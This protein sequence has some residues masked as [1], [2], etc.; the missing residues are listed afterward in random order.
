MKDVLLQIHLLLREIVEYMK[1]PIDENLFSV[2]IIKNNLDYRGLSSNNLPYYNLK[3]DYEFEFFWQLFSYDLPTSF[4]HYTSFD[5]IFE[6]IKSGRIQLSSIVG[7]ND[8]YE[9][10][11]VNQKMGVNSG[12]LITTLNA[13]L[14]FIMSFSKRADDLNQWRLYGDDGEGVML[15]FNL[16][17]PVPHSRKCFISKVQ[18]DLGI[19]DILIERRKTF[20]DKYNFGFGFK[21]I[22]DWKF[23]FKNKDYANEEE[24]RFMVKNIDSKFHS[25]SPKSYKINRYNILVPFIEL[26]LSAKSILDNF[27]FELKSITLG[28]KLK[29]KEINKIQIEE[30]WHGKYPKDPGIYKVNQ[31]QILHYR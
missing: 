17:K 9:P 30:F 1:H 10:N 20:N 11:L 24:L 7:L 6:I 4:Y 3:E 31:S 26:E 28:P 27:P 25:S 16:N 19:F 12:H 23:F 29:E 13:N 21:N 8:K 14:H 2:D 22:D 18:Y 15:E 5:A